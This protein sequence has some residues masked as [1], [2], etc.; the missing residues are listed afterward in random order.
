MLIET[1]V[2]RLNET[3]RRNTAHYREKKGWTQTRLAFAC[4]IAPEQISDIE[5][6]RFSCTFRTI[7]ML[8][9]ALKVKPHDLLD[10]R[11]GG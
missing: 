6:G 5:R 4:K 2:E 1:H 8:A 11:V 9:K 10:P 3:I 7:A